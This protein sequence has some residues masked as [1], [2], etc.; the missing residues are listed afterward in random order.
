M[1]DIKRRL[2]QAHESARVKVEHIVSNFK[3]LEVSAGELGVDIGRLE[4]VKLSEKQPANRIKEALTKLRDT[5][6]EKHQDV[7]KAIAILEF[8]ERKMGEDI[9]KDALREFRQL[10][11][12][13]HPLDSNRLRIELNALCADLNTVLDAE[14]RA[15]VTVSHD[16]DIMH[17]Q[18]SQICGQ[19][20]EL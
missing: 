15:G 17:G 20:D 14:F 13:E 9:P 2:E 3:A 10:I 8:V 12:R 16:L 6:H 11:L 18:L 4:S 19:L 1:V 7:N 5:V